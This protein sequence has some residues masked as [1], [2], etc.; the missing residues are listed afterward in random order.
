MVGDRGTLY[1]AIGKSMLGRYAVYVANLISMMILAR[2]FTPEVFGVVASIMVFYYFFQIMTEAGLGPAIINV[3]SLAPVNRDGLF[4]LTLVGGLSLGLG[5]YLLS[6]VFEWFYGMADVI[7]V[8]PFVSLSLFLFASSV[9]PSALLLREQAFFQLSTA[10]FSAECISTM[11]TLIA[12]NIVN[13]LWALAAKGTVHAFLVFSFTYYYSGKTEFGRPR[14]G[15][16]FSA[17]RPLLKF[18]SN[19]FAFNF[20]NYFSR[21]LDNILIGRYLGAEI[22]GVY[23]RAYQLMK[24]PLMLL[25]FAMTPA[26][27][28]VI[29]KH[30]SDLLRVEKIHRDFTF[31]LSIVASVVGLTLFYMAPQIILIMLGAQW[32]SVIPIFEVLTISIPAQ[33]V[34]STSGSFYQALNRTDYLLLA[35]SLAAFVVIC[36]IVLGISEGNIIS[37]CWYV[38]FAFNFNFIACYY[39]LYKKVFKVS[40]SGF[41]I[42]MLPAASVV[43]FMLERKLDWLDFMALW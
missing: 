25:T 27:Q 38:V 15:M 37:I 32:V 5:F 34:L 8:V 40:V 20:I 22:L 4:G 6:P 12:I 43:I 31:K 17:I 42:R 3:E 30:E 19:L 24:Y 36:A 39:L 23:D 28:P 1:R 41:Y 2:V 13:P 33:I 26:I 7:T 16:R 29:R 10:S 21:N 35:G 18:T 14:P 11:V 9:V